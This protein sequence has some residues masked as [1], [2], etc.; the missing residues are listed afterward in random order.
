[1][2]AFKPPP[3]PIA[4]TPAFDPWAPR[5]DPRDKL[6]KGTVAAVEAIVRSQ[7]A[8]CPEG[9]KFGKAARWD[10]VLGEAKRAHGIDAEACEVAINILMDSGVL[11]EPVLGILRP[12]DAT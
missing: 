2:T 9:A 10:D 8:N 6:D 4:K 12:T 11:Y 1:M 5:P 7:H 3:P